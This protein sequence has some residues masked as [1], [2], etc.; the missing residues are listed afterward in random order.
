MVDECVGNQAGDE[1]V[2]NDTDGKFDVLPHPAEFVATNFL[3]HLPRQAHV[4]AARMVGSAEVF[5]TS[6]D[7]ARREN[8]RHGIADGLLNGREVGMSRVGTAVRIEPLGRQ[9]LV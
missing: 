5:L 2:L 8:R 7:A 4:E 3:P 9:V 1:A 6:P